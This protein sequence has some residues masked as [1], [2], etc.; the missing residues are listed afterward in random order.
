MGVQEI[1]EATIRGLVDAFYVKVRAD[2]E[3]GPIF[4][5]AIGDRWDEHLATMVD[6]WASVMLT[7][8]RYKGNPVAVHHAVEGIRPE[9]FPRWLR[10]F[11]QTCEELLQPDIAAA[12]MG[13]ALRIADSLQHAV[14]FRRRVA[15]VAP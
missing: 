7:A 5:H 12:F 3:L 13:K 1:S 2:A 4:D 8:G 10:L 9:L 6:F 14:F 11:E 15:G